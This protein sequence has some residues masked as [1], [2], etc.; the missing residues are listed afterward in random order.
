MGGS[1]PETI[2]KLERDNIECNE[3]ANNCVDQNTKVIPFT[4]LPG[5]SVMLKLGENWVT[6]HFIDNMKFSNISL[7]TVIIHSQTDQ[8]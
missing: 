7:E 6:I 1:K 4:P 5:Y 3:D 8:H 2:T